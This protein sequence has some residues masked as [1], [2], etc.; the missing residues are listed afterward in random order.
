MRIIKYLLFIFLVLLFYN[1]LQVK[2]VFDTGL[3]VDK[4]HR[5]SNYIIDKFEIKSD[6]AIIYFT[7]GFKDDSIQIIN[8][9]NLIYS[10]K[11]NTMRQISLAGSCIIKNNIETLI[12][13]NQNKIKLNKEKLSSYKFIYLM[14]NGKKF[15][16]EYTNT[17]KS[18][19]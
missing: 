2:S 11:L 7:D 14:K 16:L 6:N 12:M 15:T 13:I 17:A 18:F 1:C 4:D 3:I 9:K 5:R 10:R 8:G 19:Q